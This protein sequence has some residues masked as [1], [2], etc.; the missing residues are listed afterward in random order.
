MNICSA[1]LT[2]QGQIMSVWHVKRTF[3]HLNICSPECLFICIF[4]QHEN[5][6]FFDIEH[7]FSMWICSA[8]KSDNN[9]ITNWW[10]GLNPEH[11]FSP[12]SLFSMSIFENENRTIIGPIT[13]HNRIEKSC[14]ICQKSVKYWKWKD[15]IIGSESLFSM[16]ICSA[17]KADKFAKC[18]IRSTIEKKS[19]EKNCQKNAKLQYCD[20]R[21]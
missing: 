6:T 3:V 15:P 17:W 9:W 12:D 7:L 2:R 11:L 4:V 16:N 20:S 21:P 19:H 18:A 10:A 14:A 1:L 8:S 5:R 13:I